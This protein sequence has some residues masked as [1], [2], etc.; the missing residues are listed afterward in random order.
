[1]FAVRKSLWLNMDAIDMETDKIRK[2]WN[3]AYKPLVADISDT[4]TLEEI[5]CIFFELGWNAAL[6][7]NST[8]QWQTGEPKEAGSYL[9]SVKNFNCIFVTT[10]HWDILKVKWQYWGEEVFSWCKLSDIKPYK[11]V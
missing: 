9:V 1:M 3:E 7:R 4:L 11:E 8:I 10:D 2:A 5:C 6:E